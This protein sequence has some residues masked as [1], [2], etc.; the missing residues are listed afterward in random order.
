V[1]NLPHQT[2]NGKD[3]QLETAIKYLQEK[4]KNEPVDVPPPPP[5]PNKSFDYDLPE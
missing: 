1:D 2:Y 4:I 3:A 5:Y